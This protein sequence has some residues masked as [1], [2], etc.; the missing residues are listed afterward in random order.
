M[1]RVKYHHCRVLPPNPKKGSPEKGELFDYSRKLGFLEPEVSA[2]VN[3]AKEIY[4]DEHA[5]APD[6]RGGCTCCIIVEDG[7]EV[8]A[9]GSSVCSFSNNFCY[10]KGRKLS[11]SRAFDDAVDAGVSP[12]ALKKA[13]IVRPTNDELFDL[14]LIK[15]ADGKWFGD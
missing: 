3:F 14:G 7:L 4:G 1:L 8:V 2:V 6:S 9:T 13:G 12:D 11:L 15:N 5:L 10:E